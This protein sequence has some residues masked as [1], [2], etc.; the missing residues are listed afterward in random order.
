MLIGHFLPISKCLVNLAILQE[1]F[2]NE[3]RY[4][5]KKTGYILWA[6]FEISEF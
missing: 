6:S 4:R 5:R 1:L 3:N 2:L